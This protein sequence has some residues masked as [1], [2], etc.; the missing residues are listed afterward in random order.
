[1]T[2]KDCFILSPMEYY[3]LTCLLDADS[4]DAFNEIDV[5]DLLEFAYSG[6][7]IQKKTAENLYVFAKSLH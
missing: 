6:M 2:N 3:Y 4:T 1:M 7:H 5:D